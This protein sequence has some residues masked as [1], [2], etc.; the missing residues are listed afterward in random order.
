MK[1]MFENPEVELEKFQVEDV[2]T[3]STGDAG[4]VEDEDGDISDDL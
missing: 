1:K 2:L 3:N 4:F